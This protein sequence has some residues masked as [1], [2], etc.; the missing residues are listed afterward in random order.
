MKWQ[1]KYFFGWDHHNMRKLI[2][3]RVQEIIER[4]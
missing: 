3:K 4:D 2:I 1:Q